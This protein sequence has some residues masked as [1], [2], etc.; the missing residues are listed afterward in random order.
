MLINTPADLQGVEPSAELQRFLQSLLDDYIVFDA[1][2][3]RR[4][5]WNAASASAWG[6][7]S[8]QEIKECLDP[9]HA[10]QVHEFEMIEPLP[11]L[12][13]EHD[14]TT[15]RVTEVFPLL[16]DGQWLQQW[17]VVTLTTEE[18]ADLQPPEWVAFGST[19]TR[20][21]AINVLLTSALSAGASALAFALAVGL[22]KA[23][24]GD[25][26]VFLDAWSGAKTAGLVPPELTPPLQA[27]A[28][29]H[30]L[31][32]EFVEALG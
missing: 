28:Q 5:Q 16:V 2:N 10:G 6:F 20:L 30:H 17:Q 29:Q 15:E 8:R 32:P 18:R 22:G 21:P 27:L 19:V 31:P 24:D 11:T 3:G 9:G 4:W 13:P 14:P 25:P 26:R 23:A 1:A 12:P 7:N